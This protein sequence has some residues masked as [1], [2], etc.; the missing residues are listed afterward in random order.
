MSQFDH[1][2][3][4]PVVINGQGNKKMSQPDS[5]QNKSK[6]TQEQVRL[7]KLDNETENF[8]IKKVD[9]NLK[10]AIQ[11]GRAGKKMSQVQLANALNVKPD[12]IKS[13]ENG[14]AIPDNRLI[15]RMQ[16]TLGVKL[17]GLSKK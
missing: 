1:Q 16:R 11:Q 10:K 13:Y 15:N 14:T 6:L 9:D 8:N 17:T 7:N 3:W 4:K 5:K 2:D 12:V